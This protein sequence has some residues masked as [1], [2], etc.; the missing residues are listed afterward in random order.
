[1]EEHK[2]DPP[3]PGDSREE[4]GSQENSLGSKSPQ[5]PT[6]APKDLESEFMTP[7]KRGKRR[8]SSDSSNSEGESRFSNSA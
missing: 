8:L 3:P 5:S 1:M 6:V 7:R 4:P 2:K